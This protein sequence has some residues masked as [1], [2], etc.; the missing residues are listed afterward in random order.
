MMMKT[1]QMS[2]KQ[3]TQK[4]KKGT[5]WKDPRPS[6]KKNPPTRL[7]RKGNKWPPSLVGAQ[8][9]QW[10]NGSFQLATSSQPLGDWWMTYDVYFDSLII[11]VM[12]SVMWFINQGPI[13]ICYQ[14]SYIIT[15]ASIFKTFTNR[16]WHINHGS[17]TMSKSPKNRSNNYWSFHENHRFVKIFKIAIKMVLK[18]GTKPCKLQHYNNR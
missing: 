9:N 13:S 14:L 6:K 12:N 10:C 1:C 2:I 3:I 16:F 15:Y 8:T 7:D 11:E 18:R 5:R 17:Q 4:R